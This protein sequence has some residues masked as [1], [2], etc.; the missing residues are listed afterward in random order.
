MRLTV[1]ALL[2]LLLAPATV[3]A[4]TRLMDVDGN[5]SSRDVQVAR[6]QMPS[7][8]ITVIV[9]DEQV[10]AYCGALACTE[11]TDSFVWISNQAT[12][13][14]VLHEIG[15]RFDYLQSLHARHR[16]R[17]LTDQLDRLWRTEDPDPPYEQFAEAWRMCAMNPR[18]PDRS[19][20]GYGYWPTV[21]IHRK[22]CRTIKREAGRQG[23]TL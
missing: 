22:V 1:A 5:R 4:R 16:F 15:H 17:A 20:A 13:R 6:A 8:P 12:R 11:P 7:P 21:Q 14:D 18:W 10:Q 9:V 19:E 23:W 3:D 2:V